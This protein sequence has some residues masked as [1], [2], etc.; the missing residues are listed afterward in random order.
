MKYHPLIRSAEACYLSSSVA[1]ELAKTHDA[2]LHVLHISTAKE[3]ELFDNQLPLR[4]K[5]ITAEVCVHHLWFS[6]T[7]YQAYGNRIKW[8]PAIKTEHDRV[9]LIKALN[10]NKIDVIAT[11][12]APHLV[13]E[14]EGNCL[15][16]ASGGPLVQFSLLAMLEMAKE[17][18][19]SIEKVVEKMCHAPA[20][21]FRIQKRGYIKSGYYADLV[22]VDPTHQTKVHQDMI[23]SKC[24]WSPFEGQTF[25][26]SIAKTF[27]NGQLVYKDGDIDNSVKGKRL[28]F[29]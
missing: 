6:D 19:F 23:L 13:Q 7:D 17:G 3:M 15:T 10:D 18:T 12:H 4:E 2:R 22:L 21:L 14:K 9:A 11:D 29:D 27:V 26:H 16:A 25:S 28:T 1:V 20:D 5:K 24:G 8:N